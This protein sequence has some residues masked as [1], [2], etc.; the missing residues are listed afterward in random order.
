MSG[1]SQAGPF[2]L[3]RPSP[4]PGRSHQAKVA[5][6]LQ[7]VPASLLSC[8]THSQVDSWPVFLVGAEWRAEEVFVFPVGEVSFSAGPESWELLGAGEE[9]L[10]Q[11]AG[12]WV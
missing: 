9:A 10:V 12:D 5:P 4:A 1:L 6:S 3:Q 7:Q 8:S 2:S 11:L